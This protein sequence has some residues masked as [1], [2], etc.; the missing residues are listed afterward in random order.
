M[1]QHPMAR[2]YDIATFRRFVREA[3][4]TFPHFHR[5]G[6]NASDALPPGFGL[7]C[8]RPEN[9]VIAGAYGT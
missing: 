3:I 4:D 6:P 5:R 9:C 7:T 1:A 8:A 2:L